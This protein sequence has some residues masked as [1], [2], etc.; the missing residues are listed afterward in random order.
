MLISSWNKQDRQ[1]T[2][3]ITL[4]HVRATSVAVAKQIIIITFSECVFVAV[5]IQHAKCMRDFVSCGLPALQYFSTLSHK[6]HN[7]RKKKKVNEHKI[8]FDRY[9]KFVW[10]TS[11][12]KTNWARYCPIRV[13]VFMVSSRYSGAI[14][15]KLDFP[16]RIFERYNFF[17]NPSSRSRVVPWGERDRRTDIKT[18]R[19]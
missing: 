15:M 16:R 2:Y 1:R 11:H 17:E 7:F 12:S 6:R 3:N 18:W 4:R 10:S 9:Y 19:S 5:G 14:W 8:C 13:S